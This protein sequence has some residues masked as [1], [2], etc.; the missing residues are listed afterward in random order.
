MPILIFLAAFLASSAPHNVAVQ[1]SS[2]CPKAG[3]IHLAVY[4]SAADFKD[5]REV[6]SLI[7]PCKGEAISLQVTLP[8]SGTYLLAA[9]HDL[10]GNGKLDRNFFGIPTEP[11]GFNQT[12]SSKWAEPKFAEIATTFDGG[13]VA[14]TLDL[15]RWKEY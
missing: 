8:E 11:Y 6:T 12:P 4:A 7:K 15:K 5:R 10:N 9:Y 2:S 1:V 14:A 3:D 13:K